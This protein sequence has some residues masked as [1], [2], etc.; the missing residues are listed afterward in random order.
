VVD[1]FGDVNDLGGSL[2]ASG[3]CRW[4]HGFLGGLKGYRWHQRVAGGL[5]GSLMGFLTDHGWPQGVMGGL[6]GRSWHQGH[7]EPQSPPR[8]LLVALGIAVWFCG[9]H[10]GFGVRK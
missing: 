6:R 5:G 10:V 4:P 2:V 8:G 1:D 9:S 7:E 3:D